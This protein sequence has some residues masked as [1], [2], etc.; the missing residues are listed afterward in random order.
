M[1]NETGVPPSRSE[2]RL[3]NLCHD[4]LRRLSE[5]NRDF[6]DGCKNRWRDRGTRS[7]ALRRGILWVRG[8]IFVASAWRRGA[9]FR[10]SA[11]L[12]R[13]VR[14]GAHFVFLA[15]HSIG[16]APEVSTERPLVCSE[17]HSRHHVPGC[18]VSLD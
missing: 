14:P 4:R 17:A 9:R 16:E 7:I 6:H 11:I 13:G 10:A 12:A 1:T 8:H 5:E 2:K 3:A 18:V 15:S